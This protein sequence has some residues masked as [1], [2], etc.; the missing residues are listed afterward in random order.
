MSAAD[1]RGIDVA[2]TGYDNISVAA[3]PRLSLTTVDPD[4][5]A[6][7][8]LGAQ[9]LLGR[10]GE[11]NHEPYRQQTITPHLVVRDSSRH[12]LR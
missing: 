1:E 3:M 4:S 9:T 10:I 12:G 2:I 11:S 5:K 8:L 7:G 6:I